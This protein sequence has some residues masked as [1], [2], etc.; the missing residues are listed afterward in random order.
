MLFEP[1]VPQYL[2]NQTKTFEAESQPSENEENMNQ[3]ATE[4][5]TNTN[6]NG[7]D[8]R[9]LP[10]TNSAGSSEITLETVRMI[11]SRII[12][13]VSSRLNEIEFD[14]NLHVRQT[15]EQAILE[16]VLPRIRET[17]GERRNSAKVNTDQ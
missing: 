10:I 14:L 7:E 3:R 11:N 15:I 4:Q 13:Q 6:P 2:F 16:Q 8:F 17:L 1:V 12:S 9:T 5:Q